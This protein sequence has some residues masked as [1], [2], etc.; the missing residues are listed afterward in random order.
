VCLPREDRAC[1]E[2]AVSAAL[3]IDANAEPDIRLANT[4][5]QRRAAWL[6][7]NVDR[8]ILPPLDD[9]A[10]PEPAS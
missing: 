7:A 6:K 1:F 4:A 10:A 2:Q 3:A 8:W 9:A 5:M